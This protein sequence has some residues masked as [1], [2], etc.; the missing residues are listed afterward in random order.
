MNSLLWENLIYLL[1]VDLRSSTKS[2]IHLEK[3]DHLQRLDLQSNLMIRDGLFVIQGNLY[4]LIP[5]AKVF[6]TSIAHF[7]FYRIN[8]ETQT[9]QLESKIENYTLEGENYRRGFSVV[10][11]GGPMSD[12]QD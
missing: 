4:H 11:F 12:V 9:I 7:Y 10:P 8:L 1:I 2:I 5:M 3:P 6:D